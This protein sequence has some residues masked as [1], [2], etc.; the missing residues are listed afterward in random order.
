[1]NGMDDIDDELLHLR[2]HLYEEERQLLYGQMIMSLRLAFRAPLSELF[3]QT[4]VIVT[5]KSETWLRKGS[6]HVRLGVAPIGIKRFGIVDA[7]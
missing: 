6:L 7:N 5:E 4:C 2:V 1:M 3:P